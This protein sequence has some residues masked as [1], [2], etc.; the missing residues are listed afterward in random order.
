MDKILKELEPIFHDVFDDDRIVLK[1]EMSAADIEA[2]DSLT[3]IRLVVAIE[4]HFG[5]MFAFGELQDLKN[6]GEMAALIA[7]KV[8]KK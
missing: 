7:E 2:W 5:I 4:K 1:P 6:V 3:H 8:G